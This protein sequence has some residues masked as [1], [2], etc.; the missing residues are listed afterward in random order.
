MYESRA[1][2]E[3]TRPRSALIMLSL[4]IELS[5]MAHLVQTS[6]KLALLCS[7]MKKRLTKL[8]FL[9]GTWEPRLLRTV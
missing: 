4:G 9:V 6:D 8:A 5:V 2:P 1:P 7:L 3:S